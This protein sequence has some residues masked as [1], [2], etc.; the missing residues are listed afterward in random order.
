MP[1]WPQADLLNRAAHAAN[2]DNDFAA[3]LQLFGYSYALA[4]RHQTLLSHA[5]MALKLGRCGDVLYACA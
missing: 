2:A 1:L 5:N 4:P 3:A